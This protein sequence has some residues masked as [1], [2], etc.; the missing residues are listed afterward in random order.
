MKQ[1]AI[2]D[3]IKCENRW[4]SMISDDFIFEIAENAADF[5]D[6]T[7]FD[8]VIVNADFAGGRIKDT[9]CE[10]KST[11]PLRNKP[12]AVTTADCDCDKHDYLFSC[13]ADDVLRLPMGTKLL[14][15][16]LRL[17][18]AAFPA[19]HEEKKSS[20]DFDELISFFEDSRRSKGALCVPKNEFANICNFV[21]RG[22]ERSHKNVQVLL[23]TLKNADGCA[24]E[25]KRSTAMN[26]LL[27][28]VKQCLRRGDTSSVC[29]ENQVMVLVIGADDN[30]G[31]LVANRIVSNF[32]S[33][34]DDEFF[35]L[36]YDIREVNAA[37]NSPINRQETNTL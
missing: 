15:N 21:L 3:S 1:I 17:L 25:H 33:K 20:V 9:I 28:A 12:M 29:S 11:L 14:M 24:D 37:N 2:I 13:G 10:A 30:G 8:A 26:I 35:E 18:I 6:K 19:A 4:N 36:Q 23:F 27:S 34:Y 32:Y 7:M 5:A 22:L 16:K 31:H